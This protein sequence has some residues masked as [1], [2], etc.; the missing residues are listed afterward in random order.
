[1][2]IFNVTHFDVFE[3]VRRSKELGANEKLV[4]SSSSIREGF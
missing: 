1:M 4:I 3:Y 2:A